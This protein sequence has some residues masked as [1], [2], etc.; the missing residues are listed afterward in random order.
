MTSFRLYLPPSKSS[1]DGQLSNWALIIAGMASPIV[2]G[3]GG[4]GLG[5]VEDREEG[6]FCILDP[7]S[8][9]MQAGD[10]VDVY[11]DANVVWHHELLADE[12]NKSLYFFVGKEWFA[13]GWIERC[14]YVVLRKDETIPDDPSVTLR[15][16]VK[17]DRPGGRDKEPHMPGHSELKMVQLPPEVIA[18]GVDAEW[19]ARGVPMT[20]QRYP[21]IAVR[22]VIQVRWGSV[23]LKPLV[24]TPEQVEGTQPIEVIAEQADI[25]AG[26]DSRNLPVRYRVHDEVWN[27]SEDWSISTNVVVDAGAWRLEAPIIDEAVDGIIDLKALNQQDVTVLI[28]VREEEFEIG[29]TVTMTW[30]GTP[31]VGKPLIHTQAHE[32]TKVPQILPL[33]I[34][35]AE[36]RAIAMG[37]A[38]V[39]HVLTKKNGDPP[40]SSKRAFASVVGDVYAYPAPVLREVMGE[41]LEPDTP[42]ATVDV[43]YPGIADG[44]FI[45]LIW[46]GTRSNGT[47]YIHGET[48]TVSENDEASKLVTL[49]LF[50][51][52]ISILANGRL[53]L[54]Y[55]VSNDQAAVYGVNESEHRL[56]KVQAIS[57]TLP[58]PIVPEAE[59]DVLDPSK[60]FDKATVLVDYS[61]T[62]KGDILTYYWTGPNPFASTS[63]WLPITT[64]S[65]GKPVSFRVDARF[66][67]GNIGQYVKVRYT[68][69]HAATGAYSY[70]GTLDLL[71]GYLVG[72]LPPPHVIQAPDARL[73]PLDAVDGVDIQVGYESMDPAL[74]TV[75]LKWLGTPGPGTSEDQEQ[76]GDQSGEVLFHLDASFVG[77]NINRMVSVG[78]GVERYGFV[79]PSESL[80]LA[81]G[82]FSDPDTQLPHP[83][84][85]QAN[86]DRQV[87][88]LATFSGNAEATLSKWPFSAVGQKVWLRLEG[89]TEN[90]TPHPIVLLAGAAISEGQA[91]SGL[92]E[93]VL[94]NELEKLG[95]DTPLELIC[96]VSF[97]GE[98]DEAFAIEFPITRYIFKTRHDWVVP[99]IQRVYDTWGDINEGGITVDSRVTLSGVATPESTLEFYDATSPAGTTLVTLEG[100]WTF[101]LSGLLAKAYRMTAQARDGSGNVSNLRTFSAVSLVTPSISSVTDSRGEVADGA[102]T[103]DTRVTLVGKASS[104]QQLEIFDNTTDSLG[105]ATANTNGD[106]TRDLSALSIA[107]H[108]L[109]A[110]A[111]YGN[112]AVSN[113]R[114]FAVTALTVP[115]ITSVQDSSGEL[116]N[117]D[118]TVDTSVTL[119]GKAS[120]QQEVEIFDNL[121]VSHGRRKTDNNGNWNM[122]IS[123]LSLTDH[124]LTAKALYGD[125]PTSGARTFTVTALNRP[126]IAS[127]LD[128]SGEVSNGGTTLDTSVTLTGKASIRQEVE[129]FD[130]LTV[131][132]GRKRTDDHGDWDMVVSALSMAD[133]SLTAQAL[134][135]DN[136]SSEARTFTVTA[137]LTPTL[138]DITDSRGSVVDKTTIE[139]SVTVTGT[140]SSGQRVQLRDGTNDIGSPINIPVAS[141]HWSANLT[142]LTVKGY[143]IKAKALYGNGQESAAKAFF[144]TADVV[145]TLTD[146]HDS[147]GSVVGGVTVEISVRVTGTGSSGQSIQL[148]DGNTNIGNPINIPAVGTSW[149]TT[150]TGLV[151][152]AYGLKAKAL[153]GNEQESAAKSFSVTAVRTPSITSIKNAAGSD[154]PPNGST[155]DTSVTLEGSASSH[156]LV[157]VFD[158]ATDKGDAQANAAG[159]WSKA[160]TG[161]ALGDHPMKIRALYG[162]GVPDSAVRSFNVR[163]PIP[164]LVINTAHVS[165]AGWIFRNTGVTPTNPPGGSYVDRAA[166]GGVLP[167][168]YT[169][170]NPGVAE[171]NINT[172]RVISC[173]NGSAVIYVTD[174]VGQVAQYS[175]SVSNVHP[176]FATGHYDTYTVCSNAAARLGGRIP[177]LAE[178]R[179][180]IN[181]YAGT[182][183]LHQ[184]CWAS[185]SGGVNK[186]FAIYPAT[187]QTQILIDFWIGGHTAYGWGIR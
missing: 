158:N 51:E 17:L 150:L 36:V 73:D 58:P 130:N 87:L 71:I 23:S 172:G 171:V 160:L 153:Y 154:I 126:T 121:T 131:S 35:Y 72:E 93:P 70:S 30:I 136:A 61:G 34:P 5:V 20:I 137:I 77:A 180:Y 155:T 128:S 178:W 76:P 18:Q 65:A 181:T 118:T 112:G 185:D 106:W 105:I 80:A 147:K 104:M 167:Y 114:N 62:L 10:I 157:K 163:S 6:V 124:S 46:E 66:V 49:Y 43:S 113:V 39:S 141:T 11:L 85:T 50:E 32:I 148:R 132:K 45:E 125:G 28:H 101:T 186:R 166:S 3:D 108:S 111:L 92:R 96:K 8:F 83:Q 151:V 91:S 140:G 159:V 156:Q 26:G 177:S 127:V 117:G 120:I 24:L 182:Q 4:I 152:K 135:G 37:S 94:R 1:T 57:P 16:L 164:P 145:P 184:W 69:K 78:Y 161:L 89:Q 139:T 84:V 129:I 119:A 27:S 170:S 102:T 81:I 13:P 47:P 79:T 123:A 48:H 146:I 14:Y 90:A 168:R 60:I 38:D 33:K 115:L 29:D 99:D 179:S 143:A 97:S 9:P 142:G 133:H 144:V 63:S 86:A 74:D 98:G 183:T 88:N 175:V 15:L 67:T 169:S 82:N 12:E 138:S 107:S 44:D 19:A 7:W 109:T 103:V 52:H 41:I 40:L 53:D 122:I 56:I 68:L 21:N 31:Q 54:W 22:D 55:R 64:L 100:S 59:N 75:I 187:G 165:L 176:I 2:D 95:H 25:L 174:G 162:S 173:G 116:N 149:E 110:K 42:M 134:Y